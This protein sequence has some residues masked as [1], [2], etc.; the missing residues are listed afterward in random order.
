MPAAHHLLLLGIAL[1]SPQ[2]PKP[3]DDVASGPRV[4]LESATGER[5]THALATLDTQD[6]RSIGGQRLR[7]E[8]LGAPP[9][10][11][12]GDQ[13]AEIQ[14]SDGDRLRGRVRG[15]REEWIQ[16]ELAGG[17]RVELIIDEISSLVWPARV[18]GLW[19]ETPKAPAE[20]DRLYRKTR[21][22]LDTIEGGVE[23]FT[24]EGVQFHGT[25]LG[26]KQIP[27]GE[28]AAL[29]IEHLP[30]KD[31]ERT[32]TAG[33]PVVVDGFDE[34]R[35]SG[36]LVR[37]TGEAC[38]I[39]RKYSGEISIPLATISGLLVDDGAL[40]YLS[41]LAPSDVGQSSPF[42]DDLGIQWPARFDRSVTNTP[43]V[44]GGRTY[45]RGVGV[46]APSK[47]TWKLD[48]SFRSLRGLIGIDDQVLRLPARGS[49]IFRV[50]LDGK[51]VWES[52]VV[53]GGDT[54]LAL[55]PI[56]V[57]SARELALEADV[58]PESFVADRAD[59]LDLLLVR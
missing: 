39:R 22:V 35:L 11:E 30:H 42:G 5:K 10:A 26:S 33:V 23:A 24:S 49:V 27:W 43:L 37:L 45:A 46:H 14:L 20:G 1:A 29:F 38:V 17:V 34:T 6:P 47:L 56:D 2:D 58:G 3:R 54:A 31:D 9:R 21:D 51:P 48:G 36:E 40:V 7:F 55:P 25:V 19:T 52:P 57:S 32:T 28:V 16:V 53:R 15:G 13:R 59:W 18:E 50:H 4:V 8:G 12:A 41:S 44:V